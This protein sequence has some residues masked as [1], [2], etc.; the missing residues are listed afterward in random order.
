[1]TE[2]LTVAEL[3][4]RWEKVLSDTDKVV[5][6]HPDVYREIKSIASDIIAK[7]LDIRDYQPTAEKLVKLLKIL[8]NEMPGSIFHFYY[9]RVSPT[10]IWHLKLFRVECC[11]LMAH[12]KAIDEWRKKK[13]AMRIVK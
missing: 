8:G 4:K 10:S 13:R 11:D 2:T 1:M 7:P 5:S 6:R 12:L 3:E 9:D